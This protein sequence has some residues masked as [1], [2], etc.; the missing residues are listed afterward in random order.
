MSSGECELPFPVLACVSRQLSGDAERD[1]A[2]CEEHDIDKIPAQDI[3]CERERKQ[4]CGGRG[5]DSALESNHGWARPFVAPSERLF[6]A[7]AATNTNTEPL[8][9]NIF[10]D[11]AS[12]SRKNPMSVM[13][14]DESCNKTMKHTVSLAPS[15]PRVI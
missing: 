6:G 5:P 14:I 4:R 11:G 10:S 3:I 8:R 7:A 1:T 2:E 13:Q 12:R 9:T 15:W